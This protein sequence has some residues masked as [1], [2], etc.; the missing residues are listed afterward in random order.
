LS[1]WREEQEKKWSL[2][3]EEVSEWLSSEEGIRTLELLRARDAHVEIGSDTELGVTDVYALTPDGFAEGISLQTASSLYR[4][5]ERIEREGTKYKPPKSH[6]ISIRD[7]VMW[8]DLCDD[9]PTPEDFLNTLRAKLRK[10]K[11]I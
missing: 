1:D 7:A 11:M 9:G 4:E 6:P 8:A 2:V 5:I 10:L 3:A